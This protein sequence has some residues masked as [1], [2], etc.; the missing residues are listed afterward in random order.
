MQGFQTTRPL[1]LNFAIFKC[2]RAKHPKTTHLGTVPVLLWR[3]SRVVKHNQVFQSV[4]QSP[5]SYTT[6]YNTSMRAYAGQDPASRRTSF[7]FC[8]FHDSRG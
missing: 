2:G 6:S 1:R 8:S 4:S 5:R 3:V 7:Q